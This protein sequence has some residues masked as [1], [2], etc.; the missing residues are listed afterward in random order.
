MSALVKRLQGVMVPAWAKWAALGSLLLAVYGLGRVHEARRGAD[1][2]A[3][4]IGKQATQATRIA[5]AQVQVV[6]DTE[7]KYVDRIRAVYVKGEEIEKRIPEYVTPADAGRF[8]VNVG[9]VR[10]LDAAWGLQPAAAP[11]ESD[12]E[13]AAVPLGDL[14][15][16]EVDNATACRVWR[17]QALGVREFYER[18]RAVTNPGTGEQH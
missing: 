3:N 12:R 7:I 2:L 6:H 8:G 17:E 18:L 16:N 1:A 4:Y 10:V 5:Q 14:A 13:P 9:F 15:A 11:A